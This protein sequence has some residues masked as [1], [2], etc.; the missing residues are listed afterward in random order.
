MNYERL[1]SMKEQLESLR[2]SIRDEIIKNYNDDFLVN[3]RNMPQAEI[4]IRSLTWWQNLRKKGLINIL[5]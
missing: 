2:S 4:L 5:V 1:L 3:L